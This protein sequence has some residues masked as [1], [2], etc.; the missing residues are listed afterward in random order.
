M[1]RSVFLLASCLLATIARS[2]FKNDNVHFKTIYPSELCKNLQ[3]YTSYLLL[4]VR[5][6]GEFADTSR[7][8]NLNIG[9]LKNAI[10]IDT[11]EIANR[12]QEISA[13]KDK[14]VFVYCSH[15]QR[16]RR[17]SKML[18]DSGFTKVYNINGGMTALLLEQANDCLKEM[19]VSPPGYKMISPADLCERLSSP[20]HYLIDVRPD[21]VW[22]RKTN[23][24]RWNALGYLKGTRHVSMQQLKKDMPA[25]DKARPVILT[26]ISGSL[27]P[28]AAAM[29]IENGFRNVSVLVE[30]IDRWLNVDR[31]QLPC[32][33]LYV[34]VVSYHIINS[35]DLDKMKQDKNMLVL[36]VRSQD[37]YLNRHKD[38]YRNIGH[39]KNA[40]HIPATE[41]KGRIGEIASFRSMPVVLY[42][43]SG[44]P[45]AFSAANELVENGFRNVSV[46]TGGIFNIRWTAANVAGMKHLN[47]WI[48]DVP[49]ENR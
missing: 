31:N 45:E 46:L 41:L 27:A 30:G 26:D 20:G 1:K 18:A 3:S 33:D 8:L 14:P 7:N 9:H 44:S 4:D 43:F 36:D 25:M 37:E 42:A 24:A 19:M 34:P 21:S 17:V 15:S 35:F 12:I 49:E 38:A 29:F 23:N 16:S 28:E 2:Q 6:P 47:G 32:K 13:Y 39:M 22:E 5:S 48:V 40:V 11:R 10:N